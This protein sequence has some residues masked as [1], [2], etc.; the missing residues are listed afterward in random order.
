MKLK[1]NYEEFKKII[2]ER[3]ITDLIH[4]T[5]TKNLYGIFEQGEIMSR[6]RLE[7]LDVKLFDILDYIQFT[8]DIRLDDKNYIN[9]SLSIP[10][11]YLFSKF[12]EKTKHD[13]TITWCI[14]KI[15]PKHIYE[16]GTLFAVTN[17][18]S[19]AAKRQFGISGDIEKFKQLF[20][21]EIQI[22]TYNGPRIIKRGNIKDKYPTDVQAE[23]LV[24][25][26]IPLNSIKQVCF[27]N[28][29]DLAKT[30]A[31]LKEFN[32]EKFVVDTQ[33]FNPNRYL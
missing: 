23:I 31:A 5:P 29:E 3:K 20:L 1:E 33:I 26:S 7:K 28:H 17:A 27:F 8:D 13:P 4:F 6:A 30:K 21:P 10:N 16:E 32:T 25:D 18:A 12:K 14:L 19:N 9:L 2:E 11:T 24:K 22:D 15:D